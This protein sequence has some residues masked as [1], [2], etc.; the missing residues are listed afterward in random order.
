MQRIHFSPSWPCVAVPLTPCIGMDLGPSKR[1]RVMTTRE[2]TGQTG[3]T[4]PIPTLKTRWNRFHHPRTTSDGSIG[5]RLTLAG[6]G[7][8]PVADRQHPAGDGLGMPAAE[9]RSGLLVVTA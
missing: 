6:A 1:P 5:D 7:H 3:Y 8:Q 9:R 2:Q 4:S